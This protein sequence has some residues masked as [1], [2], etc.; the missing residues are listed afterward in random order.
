[1]SKIQASLRNG[2]A[3]KYRSTVPQKVIAFQSGRTNVLAA[4][5]SKLNPNRLRC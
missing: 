2:N 1:M 5:R 4:P 3:T